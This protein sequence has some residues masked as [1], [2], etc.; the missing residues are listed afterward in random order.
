MAVSG[1]RQFSPSIARTVRPVPDHLPEIA[2][3]ARPARV[4]GLLTR[5][6]M[7]VRLGLHTAMYILSV[8]AVLAAA[9]NPNGTAM[10][11]RRHTS[12]I[13]ATVRHVSETATGAPVVAASEM[14]RS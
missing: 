3:V 12:R 7:Q 11:L 10:F 1:L 5:T 2:R 4:R 14:K 8:S 9:L 13:A 6:I